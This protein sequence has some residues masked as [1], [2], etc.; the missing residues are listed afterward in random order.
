MG[1][2]RTVYNI[3]VGKPARNP[4]LILKC[5]VKKGDE[6]LDWISVAQGMDRWRAFV[7]LIMKLRGP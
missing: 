3:L 4:R 6:D 5:F 1:D 7:N 2:R